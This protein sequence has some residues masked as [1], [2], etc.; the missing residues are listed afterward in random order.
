M[1]SGITSII[2]SSIASC[3]PSV[4]GSEMVQK[5]QYYCQLLQVFLFKQQ[6]LNF[7][8][9]IGVW[10]GWQPDYY[11]QRKIMATIV[12]VCLEPGSGASVETWPQKIFELHK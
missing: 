9:A 2:P 1:P 6:R 10:F 11:W 5:C 4:I 3:L 12:P 7:P 8:I